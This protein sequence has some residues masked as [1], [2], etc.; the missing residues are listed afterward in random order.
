MSS[1]VYLQ[2]ILR[3]TLCLHW[4]RNLDTEK[5]E[6]KYYKDFI[7][8]YEFTF[9]IYQLSFNN[10]SQNKLFNKHALQDICDLLNI[11]LLVFEV[12]DFDSTSSTTRY[13]VP[14]YQPNNRNQRIESTICLSHNRRNKIAYKLLLPKTDL[15]K[16]EIFLKNYVYFNRI[17]V[18]RFEEISQLLNS[19]TLIHLKLFLYQMN[20][21]PVEKILSVV[22]LDFTLFPGFRKPIE[23]TN[24][25]NKLNIANN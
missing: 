21:L 18:F 25:I 8:V 6:L 20:L 2:E 15:V 3:K 1:D 9:Q 10:F 17:N 4:L 14:E 19:S 5:F 24:Y 11:R 22:D 7:N 13:E 16:E 12:N 23:L